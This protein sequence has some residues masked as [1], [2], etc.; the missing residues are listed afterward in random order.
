METLNKAY[1][2]KADISLSNFNNDLEP[3]VKIG[4]VFD[5]DG[6]IFL[7]ETDDETPSDYGTINNNTMFYLVFNSDIESFFYTETSPIWEDSKQGWYESGQNFRYLFSLFKNDG[8]TLYQKKN[9]LMSNNNQNI[10]G[11]LKIGGPLSL[12]GSIFTSTE[13]L[14]TFL[15]DGGNVSSV[16][17]SYV[18]DSDSWF[19]VLISGHIALKFTPTGSSN[20]FEIKVE[21][22]GIN[23]FEQ[24]Y[25]NGT[26]PRESLDLTVEAG[27]LI[28][29]Y[30][31][32]AVTG[33]VG[34]AQDI[35]VFADGVDNNT[36]AIFRHMYNPD[37]STP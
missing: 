8:G 13:S 1:K 32:E 3:V 14:L 34:T 28:K 33:G 6:A 19:Y 31:K 10:P 2:G 24:S 4:S 36:K 21:K 9:L 16:S 25:P 26:H 15:F 20:P 12:S 22:N 18:T 23:V 5:N 7:I 35:K 17:T 37:K 30:T 27:D 11:G 29:V